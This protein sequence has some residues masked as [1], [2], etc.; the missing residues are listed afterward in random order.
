MSHLRHRFLRRTRQRPRPT[1]TWPGALCLWRRGAP[2]EHPRLSGY[3]LPKCAQR[4]THH[5]LAG[6]HQRSRSNVA[7][8]ARA[9]RPTRRS[10][11]GGGVAGWSG[12][13]ARRPTRRIP[14]GPLLGKGPGD[15]HTPQVP[16]VRPAE[17]PPTHERPPPLS[18]WRRPGAPLNEPPPPPRDR[19]RRRDAPRVITS[20][21]PPSG[22][23]LLGGGGTALVSGQRLRTRT[24]HTCDTEQRA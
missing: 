5:S 8:A 11:G 24:C 20:R 19:R 4:I 16:R 12:A 13:K 3:F 15:R 10:A 21:H 17:T 1:V 6:A 2:Q 14:V 23:E 7:S 22:R 9:A 18:P